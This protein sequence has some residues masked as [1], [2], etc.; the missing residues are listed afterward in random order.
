MATFDPITRRLRQLFAVLDTDEDGF[1]TWDD[2]QRIVDKYA[3]GYALT[4]SD[5]RIKPLEKAYW[6][7]WLGLLAQTT[8]GQDRL[9]QDEFVAA[10]RAAGYG[11]NASHLLEDLAQ[12]IFN[13]LD[14]DGDKRISRDEFA[15]YLAFCDI[16]GADA[17]LVFRRLDL[18]GDAFISQREVARSLRAFHLYNDD[19]NTPGGIFLGVY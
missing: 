16:S 17:A 14:A 13:V 15:R 19:L 3:T 11:T 4:K 7:Q 9:S 2:H 5:S 1:V 12:A 6:S 10:H 8:P 18:D